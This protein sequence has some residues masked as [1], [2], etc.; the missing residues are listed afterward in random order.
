MGGS[1]LD[2]KERQRHP[3]NEWRREHPDALL[4]EWT[5]LCRNDRARAESLIN[6]PL[7][8]FPVLFSLRSDLETRSFMLNPR[9]QIVLDHT[10]NVLQ[11]ADLGIDNRASFAD[12][13]DL[14]V[15]SLLWMLQTGWKNMLSTDYIQ[16]IDQTAI[17]ILLTYQRD[18]LKGMTDLV[19][20]RYKNRSQRHYLLSALLETANPGCLV[21]IA[22][23]LLSGEKAESGYARRLLSFIPEVRHA[24]D[25]SS[26][27]FAFES[28]YEENEH[29]LVYTG[30][31]NDAV[32][33]GRPF[34]I[35]YSAKYLGKTV[36]TRDGKPRQT[37]LPEEK[38]NY[39]DFL[40]LPRKAQAAL[41]GYSGHLRRQQ[42]RIWQSWI[43]RPIRQ[44]LA[45]LHMP[46]FRGEGV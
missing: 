15:H 1:A 31:T 23:Y 7:L 39:L 11:S 19:V 3:L 33:G 25:H 4:E 21:Y 18:W 40:K 13:H 17:Q 42:P 41:S 34:R 9:V 43:R 28:W 22:N 12:Q 2:T 44:Q 45:V 6:D 46:H 20:Y 38:K 32:P 35:H 30:E 37:L 29:Y 10:R 27:F 26:A 16:V 24:P 5:R 14:V 36:G 8:E